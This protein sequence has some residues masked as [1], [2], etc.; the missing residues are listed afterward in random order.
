MCGRAIVCQSSG[1]QWHCVI[2]GVQAKCYR[3]ACHRDLEPLVGNSNDWLID[4]SLSPWCYLTTQRRVTLNLNTLGHTNN[5]HTHTHLCAT[6]HT[7]SI[8]CIT[9]SS[10]AP[11]V[12]LYTHTHI[13]WSACE[14]RAYLGRVCFLLAGSDRGSVIVSLG[15]WAWDLEWTREQYSICLNTALSFPTICQPILIHS[16]DVL[17]LCSQ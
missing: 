2:L 14:D 3:L 17:L 4:C 7:S 8:Y 6:A 10:T 13:V 1:P 15:V 16:P 5:T 9:T 11:T 12:V